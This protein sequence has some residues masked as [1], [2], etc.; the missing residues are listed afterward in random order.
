MALPKICMPVQSPPHLPIPALRIE[1]GFS[2]S[3]LAQSPSCRQPSGRIIS[4]HMVPERS[5][6]SGLQGMPAGYSL[7]LHPPATVL[8]LLICFK[9]ETLHFCLTLDPANH[10]TG[11]SRLYS[12][13]L[14]HDFPG[15]AAQASHS[16]YVSKNVTHSPWMGRTGGRYVTLIWV[17]SCPN[18]LDLR[19]KNGSPAP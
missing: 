7:D 13:Q 15:S 1:P 17:A 4:P 19:F 10:E 3:S 6:R 14:G 11:R 18:G 16:L 8:K 5:K 2:G 12:G 9:Q